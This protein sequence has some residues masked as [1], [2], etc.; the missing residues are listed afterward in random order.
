MIAAY[1]GKYCVTSATEQVKIIGTN[2]AMLCKCET[3]QITY[4][5]N[6]VL[7]LLV[8]MQTNKAFNHCKI[9]RIRNSKKI[10]TKKLKLKKKK[11]LA[12][13]W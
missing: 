3:K 10:S 8:R 2:M 7:N 11:T 12:A 13:V 6:I 4:F 5:N 1:Q 9:Q